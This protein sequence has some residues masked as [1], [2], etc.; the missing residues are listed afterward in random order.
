MKENVEEVV[1]HP[2]KANYHTIGKQ[3][4]CHSIMPEL[5]G[6]RRPIWAQADNELCLSNLG[7]LVFY[8]TTGWPRSDVV[9]GYTSLP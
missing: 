1:L 8:L 3:K 4:K 6:F 7:G 5:E 2:K 9:M